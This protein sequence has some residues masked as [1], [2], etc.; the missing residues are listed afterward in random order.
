M[1]ARGRL[2]GTAAYTTWSRALRH[3]FA[4]L[5]VTD[6]YV[7]RH[8]SRHSVEGARRAAAAHAAQAPVS[9]AES[10]HGFEELLEE[11][12]RSA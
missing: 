8:P 6:R 2:A 9:A 10:E 4:R 12:G 3:W 5:D 11:W 1:R 7:H